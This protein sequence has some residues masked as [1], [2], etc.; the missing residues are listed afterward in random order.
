M[1]AQSMN[2]GFP[3]I[4][5]LYAITPDLADTGELLD[6]TRQALIGGVRLV[7]YRNKSANSIL[8][9][10]QAGL[11]RQLC[12]EFRVPLIINDHIEL[13][14]TVNADGVHVG[15]EDAGVVEARK[16]FGKD[17]IVGASC[18]NDLER[19]QQAERE[20]ADYVA[21]GAFFSSLTKPD[22]VSVPEYLVGQA[23]REISVPIVGIGGIRLTNARQVIASGC[24]A[25]AV[26]GDLF[27]SGNIT[28]QAM[29]FTQLFAEFRNLLTTN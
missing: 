7:Q 4:G 27:M 14:L 16:H 3:M 6:K 19:A 10:E 29:R 1:S 11:M 21:F 25:V 26:C 28:A 22:A 13:A 23:K 17:K 5:G 18:Y 2:P 20:G 15:R 12:N 8:L 9:K 24:A